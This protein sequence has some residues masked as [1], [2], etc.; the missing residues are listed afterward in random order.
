MTSK[1]LSRLVAL[2]IGCILLT[3]F[4][5]YAVPCVSFGQDNRTLTE[6]EDAPFGP[7]RLIGPPFCHDGNKKGS[8]EKCPA[9]HAIQMVL[10]DNG[11]MQYKCV[12]CGKSWLRKKMAEEGF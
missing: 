2:L 11:D 5:H 4:F 3:S 1:V 7:R 6:Q 12:D 9:E 8:K 10:L